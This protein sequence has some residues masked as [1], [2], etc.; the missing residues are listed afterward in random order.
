MGGGDWPTVT[1][2][3]RGATRVRGGHPWVYRAEV[4]DGEAPAAGVEVRVV[5]QRRRTLGFALAAGSA[6]AP[7]ALRVYAVGDAPRR[8]DE[9]LD[10]RLAAAV[11]RR[12]E[13]FGASVEVCRLVH[14]EADRL[15]GLFVDRWGDAAVVQTATWAFDRREARV[16]ELLRARLGLRMVVARDDGSIRDHEGLPRR[17]GILAGDGP[18]LVQVR[19]GEAVLELDL[20][21]DSKTGGFLDQRE[22]HLRAAALASP[23]G[24]AL[25]VFS[26]HGGFALQL[27]R[28]AARVLAIDEDPRAVARAR[29][30]AELSGLTNLEARAGDAFAELRALERAGRRFRVVV[31]DPPALAKRQGPVE[32]ALRQYQELNL[33]AFRLTEPEGWLVTCSCSGKV[34]APRFEDML[35]AAARAARR[36]VQIVERR[37]ASGDHP[38]LLG[39]PETD[40]LKCWI[41]R[42]L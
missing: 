26:Y 22:N 18:T 42:V 40:Y 20:L 25:D 15:P 30:N 33:R 29:R 41:L 17:K 14:G 4:V 12:N 3:A 21:E 28:R 6:T 38:T 9:L 19:E 5:D 39:V 32:A 23:G 35:V 2:S 34:T 24:E 7:I 36:D 13:R 8:L 11:R 27:A 10:D 37:G 31:L 16:A 1:V